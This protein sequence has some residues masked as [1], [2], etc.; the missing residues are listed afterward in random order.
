MFVGKQNTWNGRI[1][2]GIC[3][4]HAGPCYWS[5]AAV[6]SLA[7]CQGRIF[8]DPADLGLTLRNYTDTAQPLQLELLREDKNQSAEATALR[9]EYTVP[10]PEPGGDSAG[11]IRKSGI[12]PKRQYLVRVVLQNGRFE[13]FHAHYYPDESTAEAIDVSIYRDESTDT[14]F[15]D[16]RTLS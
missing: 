2:L 1:I 16:F 4:G 12:V 11:T 5:S 13:R 10:A 14:L 6:L 15:V 9:K 8:G 7:G 3:P